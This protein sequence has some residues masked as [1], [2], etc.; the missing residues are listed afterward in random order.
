MSVVKQGK[1]GV[2]TRAFYLFDKIKGY[3][4]F[5]MITYSLNRY[6]TTQ[7]AKFR[8]K[9]INFHNQ[10]GTK[11]TLAAFPVKRSTLFYWKKILKNSKGRLSSLVPKSTRPKTLRKPMTKKRIIGEIERLREKKYFPGKKKLKPMVDRFCLKND[12]YS[13]SESTIGRILKRNNYF[14]DKQSQTRHGYHT[15]SGKWQRKKKWRKKRLRVKYHPKPKSF[16]YIQMDTITKF[17]DGVKR[18]IITA[19]D[20]KLKFSFCLMYP[21]LNSSN[22]KDFF[23]KLQL[24][25]PVKIKA[26]QTDNGLEFLGEFDKYLK[27][28]GIIHYFIYPR[29]PKINGTVERFNQ[30][31][32]KDYI[33]PNLHLLHYPKQFNQKMIEYLL[34]YNGERP[35]ESLGQIS[36]IQYLVNGGIK[37]K[38]YWTR[39][40]T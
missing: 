6:D 37:S 34:Y 20:V 4:R 29:C 24:V 12:L 9:V 26:V 8:F 39:T 5:T 19:I 36:P 27:S 13:V 33:N 21:K 10:F 16:G 23:Q 22:S 2:P 38:M 28:F 15:A 17:I 14:K 7:V 25:Y 35:H 32:Q 30:T 40:L 18:H 31:L 11:A 1:T 3:R